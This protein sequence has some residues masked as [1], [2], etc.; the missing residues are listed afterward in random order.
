VRVLSLFDHSGVWSEPYEATHDVVRVDLQD[1]RD[2]MDPALDDLE[3]VVGILAAPPC[4]HFAN[5][6][7]RWFASKD[8]D[9]R[10]AADVALVRRVLELVELHEPAWWALENPRGRIHKLITELG[11]PRYM[12]SPHEFG[13]PLQKQ[14]WLWGDFEPPVKGPLVEPAGMRPGQP[15]AWYSRVGGDRLST[16]NYRSKTSPAFAAA[17]ARANP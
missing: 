2:V 13:E 7:A 9:G 6:G 3:C 15:P 4:T 10:T 16:K 8:A 12:F 5:S 17:F 1:G 11:A 14:T